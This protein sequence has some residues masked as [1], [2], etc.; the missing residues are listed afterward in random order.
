[1]MGKSNKM[2][3]EKLCTKTETKNEIKIRKIQRSAKL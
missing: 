2:S 1:M 3:Q